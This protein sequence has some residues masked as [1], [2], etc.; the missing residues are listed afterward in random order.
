L[1]AGTPCAEAMRRARAR[2][3]DSEASPLD[4][5]RTGVLQVHGC[6]QRHAGQ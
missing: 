6:G 5:Y 4:A 1:A 3:P 2:R